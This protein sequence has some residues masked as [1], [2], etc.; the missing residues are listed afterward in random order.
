VKRP[1]TFVLSALLI[2]VMAYLVYEY[3]ADFGFGGPANRQGTPTVEATN[4]ELRPAPVAWQTVDR[5]PDGFKV[6]LPAGANLTQ[7][8]AYTEL[9]VAEQVNLIEATLDP[10]TTYAVA[11]ADNPPVERFAGEDAEK[12][13][14]LAR[15]GALGRTQT[16]LI[17]ESRSSLGGYPAHDFLARNVGGG[18]LNARLI[19]AGTRLYMLI[20]TFPVSSARR[21]EDVNHF[22]GSFTVMAA[23]RSN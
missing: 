11:W 2:G 14:D 6:D 23:P 17:N 20:A 18:L 10:A 22:F 4:P 9:G 1:L 8:P 7:I 13:L 16:T 5:T 19:L 15:N 21:D 3:R 12:T